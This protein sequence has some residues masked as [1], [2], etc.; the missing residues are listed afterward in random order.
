MISSVPLANCSEQML[1][2]GHKT[3]NL[4]SSVKVV[5]NLKQ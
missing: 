2:V 3:K 5:E 4:S 1:D